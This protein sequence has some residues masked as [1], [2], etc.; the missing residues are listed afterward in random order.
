M[1]GKQKATL[2]EKIEKACRGLVYIS[3]TDSEVEPFF[4]GKSDSTEL[5][6][7]AA[8]AG[9]EPP[10]EIVSASFDDFFERLSRERD[11]HS[12][13]DARNAKGFA[14]LYKLLSK[15][16][17][18]KRLYRVGEIRIH[19]YAVG[20]DAKGNMRGVSMRAVET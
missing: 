15:Q 2:A 7:F 11:W 4:G 14:K 1:A 8:G 9:I 17:T 13:Y 18:D 19:I 3:E 20:L 5:A 6:K 10:A 16:L 12:E